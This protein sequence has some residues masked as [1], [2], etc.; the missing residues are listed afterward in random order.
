MDRN[1]LLAI[2]AA[3]I[4]GT[5]LN[6]CTDTMREETGSTSPAPASGSVSAE[7]RDASG[8]AKGRATVMPMGG[9]LH[10]TASVQG[11]APGTY[12][13]H[14]HAT[15][16]CTPPDFTSAGP[17]WNPASRQHGSQNPAGPHKG[18]LPNISVA[19][20][21]TGQVSAHVMDVSLDRLLDADGAAVVVHAGPDDYKTDPSGNS[22]ARIACG[23][24]TRG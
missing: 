8:A 7:L 12:A 22:G 13:V 11:M 18:D 10:V 9:G 23:V 4:T 1:A 2:A 3:V 21:G 19:S 16:A 24:L 15:G 6:A 17:H 14:L 5:A 20:S